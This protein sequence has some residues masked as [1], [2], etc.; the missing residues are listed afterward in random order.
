ME[1][2]LAWAGLE[3]REQPTF[4]EDTVHWV[5]VKG[6]AQDNVALSISWV[7]KVSSHIKQNSKL[8]IQPDGS[9]SKPK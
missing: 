4:K 5:A 9:M 6:K 1:L 3:A 7:P 2:S 8:E